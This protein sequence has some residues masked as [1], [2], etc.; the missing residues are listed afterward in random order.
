M[1]TPHI[2]HLLGKVERLGYKYF[3]GPE[4]EF[5]VVRREGSAIVPWITA[6][7]SLSTDLRLGLGFWVKWLR[8]L[9]R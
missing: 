7:C 3:G 9:K 5:N 8:T 4:M 1:P 2:P 6:G